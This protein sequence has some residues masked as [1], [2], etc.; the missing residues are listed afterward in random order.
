MTENWGENSKPN[1]LSPEQI[2]EWLEGHRELM[3]EIWTSNPGSKEEW[4]RLNS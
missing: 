4:E 3:I 2:I 1:Q